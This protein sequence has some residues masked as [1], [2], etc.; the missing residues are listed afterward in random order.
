VTFVSAAP[1][2]RMH[3]GMNLCIVMPHVMKLAQQQ[4]TFIF[5]PSHKSPA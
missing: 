5:P 3:Q 2:C 1:E 4:P